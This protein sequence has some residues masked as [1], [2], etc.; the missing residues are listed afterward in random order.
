MK[1]NEKK[2]AFQNVSVMKRRVNVA[3]RVIEYRFQ[4]DKPWI[5]T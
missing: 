2:N 5:K 3:L 1:R 4:G